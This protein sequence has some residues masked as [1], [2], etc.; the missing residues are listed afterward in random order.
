MA[1]VPAVVRDHHR[2]RLLPRPSNVT[3]NTHGGRLS[4]PAWHGGLLAQSGRKI[5]QGML[6]G[7]SRGRTPHSRAPDRRRPWA[8][9]CHGVAGNGED[10]V[11]RFI[12]VDAIA[13]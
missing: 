10:W 9:W 13:A 8:S 11:P 3:G 7:V 2:D 6:I 1:E 12:E 4:D 5:L